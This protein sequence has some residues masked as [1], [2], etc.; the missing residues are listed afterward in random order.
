LADELRAIAKE[1]ERSVSSMIKRLVR[2]GIA[3]EYE[4]EEAAA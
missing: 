3:A 1:E 4:T 2:A